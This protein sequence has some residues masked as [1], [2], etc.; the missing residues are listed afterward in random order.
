MQERLLGYEQLLEDLSREREEILPQTTS[1][2]IDDLLRA[3]SNLNLEVSRKRTRLESFSEQ[4]KCYTKVMDS[5][6]TAIHDKSEMTNTEEVKESFERGSKH[7][8]DAINTLKLTDEDDQKSKFEKRRKQ[9]QSFIGKRK[10]LVE[11]EPTKREI[12]TLEKIEEDANEIEN[13]QDD[14]LF[15]TNDEIKSEIKKC[16]NQLETLDHLSTDL[17]FV[18]TKRS[19]EDLEKYSIVRRNIISK[20]NRHR[21]VLEQLKMTQDILIDLEAKMDELQSETSEMKIRKE[22][23][24]QMDGQLA[25]MSTEVRNNI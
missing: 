2:E 16:K 9:L 13:P 6:K 3:I 12:K 22:I 23:F 15:S 11:K 1:N 10:S 5:V 24:D 18:E 17:S 8:E 14:S 21:K 25:Q 4:W 7:F 20:M 19:Q